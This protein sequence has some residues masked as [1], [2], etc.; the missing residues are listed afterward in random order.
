MIRRILATVV[1]V[2][3]VLLVGL[4]LAAPSASAHATVEA[5]TPSTGETVESIPRGITMRFSEGVA[6]LPGAVHVIAPDGSTASQGAA[7]LNRSGTVLTLALR[8]DLVGTRSPAGTYTVSWRVT[9]DDGHTISG[10][11][12]FDVVRPSRPGAVTTTPGSTFVS[13]A[14]WVSRMLFVVGIFAV[15][16]VATVG[17]RLAHGSTRVVR[18]SVVAAAVAL[19]GGFGVLWCR[20]AAANDVGLGSAL[21]RMADLVGVSRP[22]RLDLLRLAPLTALVSL[23]LLAVAT[24]VPRRAPRGEQD[25]PTGSAA[26]RPRE[27][28]QALVWGSIAVAALAAFVMTSMSGH[29]AVTPVAAATIAL[30][31]VHLLAA[32]TW[33]GGVAMLLV[34]NV[35][36]SGRDLDWWSALA[37]LSVG[38]LAVTGAAAAVAQV[39]SFPDL[40]NTAYGRLLCTKVALVALMGALGW[41]N[42]SQLG[43]LAARVPATVRRVRLEALVALVVLGVTMALVANAPGSTFESSDTVKPLSK[44]LTLSPTLRARV[45][46]DPPKRGPASVRVE[47]LD[48]EGAATPVDAATL[49]VG[50]DRVETTLVALQPASGSQWTNHDVLFSVGGRWTLTVVM[51]RRGVESRATTTVRIR[52]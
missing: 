12:T 10:T 5:T 35:E 21:G 11:W 8:A 26:T 9:S 45:T 6:V 29:A 23:T 49:E 38:T 18:L 19:V 2:G 16:A 1:V 48:A 39:P 47:A 25:D 41:A 4:G 36:R 15:F 17:R 13:V 31:V 28:G 24:V 32:A 50:A 3:G 46:V 40:W 34:G 20:T 43:A 30:D 27:P 14:A 33:V 7:S 44:V 52:S 37:T 51:V 22:A 42:R